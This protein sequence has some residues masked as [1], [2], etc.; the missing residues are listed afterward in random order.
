MSTPAADDL[1]WHCYRHP[2][3]EAG[4]RCRRCERAICPDCMI[5]AP[6]GFQ[7]PSCVKGAPAVRTARSLRRD[8]YVTWVLVAANVAVFVAGMGR[9]RRRATSA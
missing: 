7:C 6:V 3:R 9:P 5:S 4:V 1:E 2:K 8:P